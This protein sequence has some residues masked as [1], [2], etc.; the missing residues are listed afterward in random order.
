[1]NIV[2]ALSQELNQDEVVTAS[3]IRRAS[4]KYKV[5]KIPKRTHGYRVIA[6]PSKELKLYQKAAIKLLEQEY[7]DL[8]EP[9]NCATAYR[10][11]RG[12]KENAQ[13]HAENPY[14]LKMDFVDFFNSI[15]PSIF[16]MVFEKK[17]QKKLTD[18]EKKLYE[19]LFFWCPSRQ[20]DNKLILSIGAPSS[21]VVSNFC[22]YFFDEALQQYCEKKQIIYSRYADDLAFSTAGKGLLFGV[23]KQVKEELAEHFDRSIT[24]NHRKTV[25]SSKAHNR[26]I[27]GIT[28]NNEGKPSL[29]RKR[30]RYIKH[31]VFQFQ[32][33]IL[34]IEDQ[35]HLRG[36]LAFTK[37][38]EPDFFEALGKK[39]GAKTIVAIW[40]CNK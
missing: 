24:I 35:M 30:K 28:L 9:H 17:I 40:E 4:H 8:L 29:G 20:T 21:P 12:I 5:Y 26:H 3:F 7:P 36:L 2:T 37:H 10:I 39:Y 18:T 31:L 1:M 6:Q 13:K 16:W 34:N 22:L 11:G 14:L 27:T 19:Q 38:I 15:K 23:P 32:S 33:E 25:F